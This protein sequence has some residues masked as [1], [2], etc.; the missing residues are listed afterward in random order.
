[1]EP[2]QSQQNGAQP[3]YRIQLKLVKLVANS[4]LMVMG[5]STGV[6]LVHGTVLEQCETRNEPF[7][8]GVLPDDM[9][10]PKSGQTAAEPDLKKCVSGE[11]D[12]TPF[13]AGVLPEET[14][15]EQ[16][17]AGLAGTPTPQPSA[18]GSTP[19]Q[20]TAQTQTQVT[21]TT[22]PAPSPA[23]QSKPETQ[24]PKPEVTPL[25]P[26]TPPAAKKTQPAKQTTTTK[27]TTKTTT[28]TKTLS[29][30]L[31]K[32]S[33]AVAMTETHNCKDKVKGGSALYNNC[34]GF[35]KNGKFMRFNSIEE[36]HAYFKQLW[37]RSYKSYPNLRLAKIYSGNDNPTNWL[38]NVN[39]YYNTL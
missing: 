27:T 39:Y 31:D 18:D 16:P 11:N 17:A 4:L 32:L 26:Q 22:A 24:K 20:P 21:Q 37:A 38:K 7:E 15:V 28:T 25:P 6:A 3:V 10:A 35:R 33:M 30:D 5:L 12:S 23:P 36:S 34:H 14:T 13:M 19:I 8:A 29:Y 9:K 2:T 1:M